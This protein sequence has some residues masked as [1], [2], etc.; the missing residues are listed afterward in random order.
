MASIVNGIATSESPDEGSFEIDGLE[1]KG[2][3]DLQ[4]Y[5]VR[6]YCLTD[7]DTNNYTHAANGQHR[8]GMF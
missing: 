5:S 3:A 4:R 6:E 2:F 7:T 8:M 1:P